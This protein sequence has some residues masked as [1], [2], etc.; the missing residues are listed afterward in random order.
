M[1]IKQWNKFVE[2]NPTHSDFSAIGE[3]LEILQTLKDHNAMYHNGCCAKVNDRHY[4]KLVKKQEK[5]K[6]E[7]ESLANAKILHKREK[8]ELGMAVYLFYG[9][10]DSKEQLCAAGELHLGSC[11]LSMKHVKQFNRFG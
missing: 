8:I 6:R 5:E 10:E 11:N 4:N 3:S 1:I 7:N 9:E 2:I